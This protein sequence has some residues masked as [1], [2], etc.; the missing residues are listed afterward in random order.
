MAQFLPYLLVIHSTSCTKIFFV[1][2]FAEASYIRHIDVFADD[3]LGIL[4][5]LIPK[6]VGGGRGITVPHL[7]IIAF[8]LLL[9]YSLFN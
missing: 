3:Y 8:A 7:F 2:L 1:A 6:T 5:M 9:T 4:I